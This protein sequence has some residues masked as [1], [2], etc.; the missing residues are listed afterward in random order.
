MDRNTCRPEACIPWPDFFRSDDLASFC[1]SLYLLVGLGVQLNTEFA[2]YQNELV[3]RI[4]EGNVVLFLG[5]GAS[6]A[7][8]GPST[9]ELATYLKERFPKSDQTLSEF[10]EVCQDVLD[11]LPYDRAQLEEAVRAKLSNLQASEAHKA[12]TEHPWAAIFTT[13]FDDLVELSYRTSKTTRRCQPISSDGFQINVG[14]KSRVYLFKIMGSMDVSDGE[15]GQMV[16]S[17]GDHNK[18]LVRRRKF[19]ESLADFV[20]NG[21]ILFI[22]YSFRDRLVLDVME[23]LIEINGQDRIPWSYAFFEEIVRDEKTT[24]IFSRHR[25]IP[26]QCSFEELMESLGKVSDKNDIPLPPSEILLLRGHRLPIPL[27]QARLF[28][29]DFEFLNDSKLRADPGDK[30]D[31]F[32]GVN[33]SWGAF[34]ENWDFERTI[35]RTAPSSRRIAGRGRPESLKDRIFR[36]IRRTN[37]E[38]NKIIL[39]KGIP[40]C[41]KT[42]LLRR[43]AYD[44]Y[45]SGEAPVILIR[46]LKLNA[47]YRAISAFA[48]H[49]NNQLVQQVGDESKPPPLKL[50]I[51]VDDASTGIRHL[52]RLRDFLT[53]RGRSVLILAGARSGEWDLMYS[54]NPFSLPSEDIYEM[55]E[56]L[57]DQERSNLV[58]HLRQLGFL[59]AASISWEDYIKNA[60]EDSFFAAIY[61]LV[62]PA[63]RPLNAII[64]NQYMSLA[65]LSQNAFR[66]ISAFH[67]FN[68]PMNLELLVRS[69]DCSYDDF[70][71]NVTGNETSDVLFSEED[72]MGNVLYRT[73][74]RIIAQRTVEFFFGDPEQQKEV[75]LQVLRNCRLSNRMERNLVVKLLIAFLG[76]NATQRRLVADQQRQVF[77]TVCA[78][79]PIRT[80]V[81]HWGI[82]E[83]NEQ[84][85]EE[86]ERL[87]N[88]SLDLPRED[89]DSFRGET[90][91]NILTS[92]GT[93]HSRVGLEA[94]Q[95]QG[96]VQ[97]DTDGH[98][99]EAARCFEEA[100]YGE[101]PNAYAYHGQANM[102]LQRAQRSEDEVQRTNQLGIALQILSLAKDNLNLGDLQ[103]LFELETRVWSLL[104]DIARVRDLIQVLKND[105]N[106]ARGYYIIAEMMQKEAGEAE[107]S[108]S[109]QLLWQSALDLIEEGLRHFPTDEH[110]ARLRVLLIKGLEGD[111][112]PSGYYSALQNWSS[113]APQPNAARLYELGRTSFVLGYYDASRSY[114]QELQAGIGIGNQMRTRPLNPV[115][116]DNGRAKEFQGSVTRIES[117][118]EGFLRC[119]SLRNLRSLMHFRPIAA[120]FTPAQ[121]DAVTFQIEFSF[122]GP[123]ATR[124]TRV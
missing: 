94:L 92:L 122:R 43:I 99:E 28:A 117:P 77:S 25:I 36:E 37:P 108:G 60:L 116:D 80:V 39:L 7:A 42:V 6:I 24:S 55:S 31:F 62:D 86:A 18:A 26:L 98:F 105:Y 23:E 109:N 16:L 102:W 47:D 111:S 59:M 52:T 21:T 45:S 71:T 118:Y 87:L 84:N 104:G 67:Q 35:Y 83:S 54:Q 22:G 27:N 38:D 9:N 46:S 91:Q 78:R 11:T 113:I 56:R 75:F 49:L 119:E 123:T 112:N 50:I 82:L 88:W 124:V 120:E 30:D 12:I 19:F 100:K 110:C 81:H 1:C 33:Q 115:L 32:R 66:L 17:R 89:A 57:T 85:Y 70:Y 74:H 2:T 10:F 41:G 4:K 63:K 90:D 61:E 79:N 76:P 34:G 68:L 72:E 15:S 107:I 97:L 121:G 5:A 95:G 8:G 44:V 3:S 69:L 65:P 73:H 106:T 53:S 40:G 13:N 93:L 101:F 14:D 48:E 64:Q 103:L 114:F 20:K 51:V 96:G 29:A 58:A